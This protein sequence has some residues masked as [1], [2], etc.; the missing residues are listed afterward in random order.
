MR[1]FVTPFIAIACLPLG[2]A[3]L[4]LENYDLKAGADPLGGSYSFWSETTRF[5]SN[6]AGAGGNAVYVESDA[7]GDG[8]EEMEVFLPGPSQRVF[9]YFN[10]TVNGPAED[11]FYGK[12]ETYPVFAFDYR[13]LSEHAVSVRLSIETGVIADLALAGT[14]WTFAPGQVGTYSVNLAANADLDRL[15]STWNGGPLRFGLVQEGEGGQSSR[16]LYDNFR[17][18]EPGTIVTELTPLDIPLDEWTET[19]AIGW[20]FGFEDG[21]AWSLSLG[22]VWHQYFPWIYVPEAGWL[23]TLPRNGESSLVLYSPI[24]GYLLHDTG[25]VF[26]AYIY[27]SE[28]W[29]NLSTGERFHQGT[30][31]GKSVSSEQPEEIPGNWEWSWPSLPSASSIIAA[32]PPDRPVYGLYCWANE[33]VRYHDFIREMGWRNF[34]ISGP[35]NDEAMQLFAE[36]GVEIMYTLATRLHGTFAADPMGDWRNRADYDSDEAFV[37]DYVLGVEKNIARY[38]PGER[39]STIF[40][41]PPTIP[42]GTLKSITSRISGTSICPATPTLKLKTMRVATSA[43]RG[44]TRVKSSTVSC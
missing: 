40:R 15:I 11:P 29:L 5:F 20:A 19:D 22:W 8:D 1:P 6:A 13:N 32:D 10:D 27:A 2:L 44:G 12:L 9:Q 17:L 41:M 42:S 33:Y 30:R 39:S 23:Y 18:L 4:T 43:L 28:D 14:Q 35:M 26:W 16:I 34:R 38:G 31:L 3:A 25:S 7:D 21:L 36:D 24:D 37:A